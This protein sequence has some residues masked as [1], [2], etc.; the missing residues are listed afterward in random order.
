[1]LNEKRRNEG[2]PEGRCGDRLVVY[3]RF[4]LRCDMPAQNHIKEE[5]SIFDRDTF[6]R[7][8]EVEQT[9]DHSRKA[10]A[11]L[12]LSIGENLFECVGHL[13]FNISLLL[14]LVLSRCRV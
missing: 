1:M 2:E 5:I 9:P 4:A 14:Y 8:F 10:C 6:F 11:H 7:G 13:F 12:C 3:L